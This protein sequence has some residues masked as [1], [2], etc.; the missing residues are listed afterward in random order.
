LSKPR[1]YSTV[2][3]VLRPWLVMVAVLSLLVS[4]MAPPTQAQGL[5]VKKTTA[6]SNQIT[7]NQIIGGVPTRITWEATVDRNEAVKQIT[8]VFPEGSSLGEHA[9]TKATVLEGTIRLDTKFTSTISNT[10]TVV[11]FD[12]LVES[13]LLIRLEMFYVA[14]PEASGEYT[15]TGSYIDATGR[16]IKLEE[17]QT[18]SVIAATTVD[19]ITQWMDDQPWVEAWN[20]VLFLKIFLN[21]QYLVAS[22][23]A[24]FFGWLRS[25]GLVLVGFPLAIP[26]GLGISFLRMAR[27]GVIRFFAAIYVNVIRGTPLFLQIYIAFFGLPLLGVSLDSYVLG[28]IVLAV[29]SS[30]Y[31]A[32]IFRAGIQSIHKGQFEGSASLG[33]NPVQTMFHV[34]LPQTIRRVI[35]TAT[36]E[37][38]LLY[39]DT[40][41]LAAVGVMEQMMFAKS[42]V[43]SSGN[44]TPYIVSAGYYLLV[45]LPLTK[46]I[47]EFEKKL[48]AAEGSTEAP[49]KKPK[50]RLFGIGSIET[51]IP[52]KKPDEPLENSRSAKKLRLDEEE[53]PH[54][55]HD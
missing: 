38:I 5:T 4:F 24:L 37:F 10:Q 39:K 18:I 33:M 52:Q 55:K 9:N 42:L 32:E 44:M 1:K 29:N 35:P 51:L 12:E 7:G 14:L 41:R 31:L 2:F 17:S 26:I 40:A 43:A 27:F 53:G 23:P 15:L 22:V 47:A 36:S 13:D 20:S 50:R 46:I 11:V 45:T 16:E 49:V 21:P 25:L 48:A 54:D 8:L 6:T 19:Q 34:I 30:A 28:I 3:T